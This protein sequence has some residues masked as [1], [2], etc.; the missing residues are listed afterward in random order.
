MKSA[1][2][3]YARVRQCNFPPLVFPKRSRGRRFRNG[4]CA[5]K[6]GASNIQT[7]SAI[8]PADLRSSRFLAR[9]AARSLIGPAI[10]ARARQ[11]DLIENPPDHRVDHIDKRIW[12][13]VKR[14]NGRQHN[15]ARF[16][17]SDD[18]ARM[19]QIPRRFAWLLHPFVAL[20]QAN[21]GRA[22]K[23]SVARARGDSAE[24]RHRTRNDHHGIK[25]RRAAD[26]WNI[27]IALAVL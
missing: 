15:R 23:R 12:A 9:A 13:A 3:D 22:Q 25:S 20:P 16:Q 2:A 21:I 17:Q 14:W 8:A 11:A 5:P 19:D 7:R 6:P 24:S 1:E 4:A 27:E 18:V 10:R 26:E